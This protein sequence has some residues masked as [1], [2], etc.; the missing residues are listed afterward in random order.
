MADFMTAT[1]VRPRGG[2]GATRT[3]DVTLDA[4]WTVN[5]KPHGGYLLAV[6]GRAASQVAETHPHLLAVNASFLEA[7]ERG[8][9][10]A[11][12]EP[13]REG[14]GSA[15]LRAR[16]VQD[17]R[18][19]VEC[20]IVQGL[21]EDE[22]AWWSTAVPEELPD[23]KDC[24]LAPSEVPELGLSA[25]FLAMIEH[26]LDPALLGF[27][28]GQP[29]GQGLVR[30]WQRMADESGWDPLSVLVALD[31]IPSA[32]LDLGIPGWAP[33]IQ[34]SAYVRSLPAAGAL[35]TRLKAGQVGA[36][37][38]DLSAHLW[39]DKGRLVAQASQ[40]AA[41]RIPDGAAPGNP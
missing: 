33:T 35:R 11:E 2:T 14:R 28:V 39:D 5:G 13:L 32:S 7:A 34:F 19:K 15:Q 12:V 40:I 37:T 22:D 18:V 8:D 27:A 26:R 3:F 21:L 38:M 29:S 16:L 31:V 17:D 4:Q 6:L 10:V 23:E 41:V 1:A 25:P 30:G 9:A 24:F 20:L 36:Q